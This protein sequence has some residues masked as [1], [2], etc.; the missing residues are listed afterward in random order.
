MTQ[1]SDSFG[2]LIS[3]EPTTKT[4][5]KTCQRPDAIYYKKLL[6]EEA[7]RHGELTHRRI[8]LS[9][10]LAELD[11][12]LMNRSAVIAGLERTLEEYYPGVFAGAGGDP[13]E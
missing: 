3:F 11:K 6:Q 12:E 5:E 9:E 7:L 13:C 2:E 1:R 8:V 10:M 4:P